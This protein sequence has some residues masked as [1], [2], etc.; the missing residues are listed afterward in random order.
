[1]RTHDAGSRLFG[2]DM[3]L[4]RGLGYVHC[5]INLLA[6]AQ[7]VDNNNVSHQVLQLM[8]QKGIE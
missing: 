7:W 8:I 4:T 5:S 3:L 6:P 2:S 1:M